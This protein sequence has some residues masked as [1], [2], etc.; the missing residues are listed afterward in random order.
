[1]RVVLIVL[2]VVVAGWGLAAERLEVTAAG[3]ERRIDL[4]W[5]QPAGVEVEGW[6][7]WRAA[8]PGGP[9]ERLDA[10][11][12]PYPVLSDFIGENG[13]ALF[14]RV[15]G[16]R[17]SATVCT[18]AV[19]SAV[20]RAMPDEE[21]LTSVQ[22]ATF[23]YFW[24]YGH[25]VSGL[26]RERLGSGDTV[27]TGGSGFGIMAIVV[28]VE[29]G[30]VTREAAA[31][32]VLGMLRFL[33][34]R[35]TRYHGAWAHWLNGRTGRTIPFS[36]FDDGG[37]LVETSF[38]VQGL[39]TARRYFDRDEPVEQELR[40]RATRLWEGVEWDW[41]R[42]EPK[43]AQLLWHWSPNH[44][45]KIRHRIGGH[46]NECL[47]TYLLAL[48]SPTHP[49]PAG[50]YTNGW[51]GGNVAGFTNGRA[52]FGIK[53]P[54]GWPMG[55]PL[56]FTQ[57]SFLGFD[58]R[59]WR[60]PECD[61]FENNRAISRIHHA[62]AVRNPGRH[63]GYGPTV[64]GLTACDGPDGYKAREPR[65]DDGTVAPTAALSAMPYVPEQS[66]AALRHYYQALGKRLWGDFGFRDAFNLDRDWF[67]NS[68]LAIDQGPIVVM[69][70]NQRTG[71]CWRL[72]MANAEVTAGLERAGWMRQPLDRSRRRAPRSPSLGARTAPA[73][74]CSGDGSST[75]RR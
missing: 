22:E 54:V 51:L 29:R 40:Q 2:P 55:G 50:C 28:G 59:G 15:A 20:S 8:E 17:G 69:I 3:H 67:A 33:E 14:Y 26:A 1:M 7:V 39:L 38:L 41:Y 19:V 45:W 11:P 68:Y 34:E 27:T 23:R 72:F 9:F 10:Q 44:G 16:V 61:Y 73:G 48:A 42:G 65:Y 56:F 36:Q 53:Q 57:F 5:Q 64:W 18:S 62:Y 12:R 46:F 6:M 75:R 66:L 52:Y 30:F 74:A 43:G 49:I 31:R 37:D 35:A 47:I 63:V 60:A 70:E 71:L 58:P 13:R 25:P 21:L 24:H 4:V 32:R